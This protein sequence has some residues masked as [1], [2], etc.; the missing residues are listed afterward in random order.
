MKC[1]GSSH[2]GRNCGGPLTRPQ[3]R[4]IRCRKMRPSRAAR[5]GAGLAPIGL[6]SQDH[7]R[8][9][10]DKGRCGLE[11]RWLE[12]LPCRPQLRKPAHPPSGGAASGAA[13]CALAAP[14][15]AVL[16][17]SWLEWILLDPIGLE[18]ERAGVGLKC[19]GSCNLRP[20]LQVVRGR[21]IRCAAMC[22]SRAARAG[23]GLKPV[24][25]DSFGPHRSLRG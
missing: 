13:R 22:P 17:S 18:G 14:S 10:R 12:S 11:L 8:S 2:C 16:V 1:G 6:T 9:L 23:A 21:G 24:G 25:V 15:G 7:H 20:W 3:G 19:G 5:A 4:G